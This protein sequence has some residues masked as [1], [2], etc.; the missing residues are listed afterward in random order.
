[1]QG[2][3]FY[4]KDALLVVDDFAPT[5]GVSRIPRFTPEARIHPS[6]GSTHGEEC[7]VAHGDWFDL[8]VRS[9]HQLPFPSFRSG[10][11]ARQN[12]AQ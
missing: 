9:P 10:R 5:R 3:A 1:L 12:R 4:A 11:F 7:A 2:L 8:S 6:G